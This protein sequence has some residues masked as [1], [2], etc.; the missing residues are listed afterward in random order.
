MPTEMPIVDVAEAKTGTSRHLSTPI[1]AVHA[2]LQNPNYVWRTVDGISRE[3]GLDRTTVD[4]ILQFEMAD[5]IVRNAATDSH[6]RSL[7]ATRQR[8][9]N[10]RSLRNRILSVLSDE[11]R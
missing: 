3:T 9:K 11:V 2:A 5:A 1:Q 8:Y 7:F 6:G 10:T 4:H